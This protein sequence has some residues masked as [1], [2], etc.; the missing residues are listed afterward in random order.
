MSNTVEFPRGKEVIEF[1]PPHGFDTEAKFF[2]D[3]VSQ[4]NERH[5]TYVGSFDK[6]GKLHG[7]DRIPALIQLS[8]NVIAYDTYAR[9]GLKMTRHWKPTYIKQYYGIKGGPERAAAMLKQL[10]E[11]VTQSLRNA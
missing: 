5:R 7:G 11:S 4:Y 10:H 8:L 2:K 9:T 1:T 6:D 3:L